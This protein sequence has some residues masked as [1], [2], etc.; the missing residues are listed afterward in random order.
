MTNLGEMTMMAPTQPPT[1]KGQNRLAP[2]SSRVRIQTGKYQQEIAV[3]VA[4]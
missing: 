1:P 2:S 3:G 4:R